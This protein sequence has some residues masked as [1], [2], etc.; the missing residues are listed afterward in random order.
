MVF[1]KIEDDGEL[2]LLLHSV[3]RRRGFHAVTLSVTLTGST[4]QGERIE[5]TDSIVTRGC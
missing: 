2:D 1:R 4:I 5:G 3:F